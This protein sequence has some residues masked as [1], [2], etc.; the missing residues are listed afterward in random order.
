LP[1]V[2]DAP[3][4][5]FARVEE[6]W[7][8]LSP[9]TPLG[10]DAKEARRV[11]GDR[12]R[13]EELYDGTTAAAA[14]LASLDGPGRDSLSYRLSR[15]PRLPEALGSGPGGALEAID[16]FLVKKF[17]VNY[18]AIIDILG[19]EARSRFSLAFESAALAGLLDKGGS[20]EESFFVSDAFD[21]RLAP[22]RE[23]IRRADAEIGRIRGL[24]ERS[25]MEEQALDFRGRSFLVLPVAASR[26]LMGREG[27]ARFAVEPYDSS[28]CVVRIQAGAEELRASA[29]R[30]ALLAEESLLEARAL[31]ELSVAILAEGPRIALYESA[32]CD[33]DLARARAVLAADLRLARP[34]LAPGR[35]AIAE[36]RLVP[37]EAECERLSRRYR[38]LDLEL[39]ERA[40]LLFGSNMGG[41]TVALQTALCLQILAQAGLF[42]PALRF[43]TEVHSRIVYAGAP[44]PGR[45][46]QGR[47]DDGLS[48]FG[49]EVDALEAAW[50]AARDGGAFVVLDELGRTTSSPEAEALVAA[51][52]EAFAAAKGTRCL[53]AT[54]FRGAAPSIAVARLRMA[55]LDRERARA[56]AY[57]P[58]LARTERIRRIGS[59]MRYELLRDEGPLDAYPRDAYPR[60]ESDAL[61]VAALLGLD[62]AILA[63]A[64]ARYSGRFKPE[65]DRG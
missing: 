52:S 49:R 51:A 19:D 29:E 35:L 10:K 6:V 5:D 55:G 20:D 42:V 38:P 37:C 1:E 62:E 23:G 17:L 16:V 50:L 65:G 33:F 28:S 3:A 31:A 22:V 25:A 63:G 14:A 44:R 36:G 56:V 47:D 43:E 11:F 27:S 9:L 2:C 39:E 57:D 40:A 4:W 32:L 24:A 18:R 59:L 48:G 8:R 61:E 54:H 53:L 12:E 30:E 21:S 41:K 34:I 46:E 7:R 60:E 26:D 15:I 13:I 64:R 45:E 58:E